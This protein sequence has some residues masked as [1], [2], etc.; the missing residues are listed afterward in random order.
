MFF[1][2]GNVFVVLGNAQ[3]DLGTL[4]DSK[5]ARSPILIFLIWSFHLRLMVRSGRYS[6]IHCFQNLY[7]AACT[8]FHFLRRFKFLSL[9]LVGEKLLR[10]PITKWLGVRHS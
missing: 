8:T 3:Y 1:R 7:E 2:I 4:S 10:S 9:I 5:K 6:W